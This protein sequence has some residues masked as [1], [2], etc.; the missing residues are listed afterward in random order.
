M[1]YQLEGTYY[2]TCT[3]DVLC[4]CGATN[5]VLPADK[6]RCKVVLGFKVDSGQ[7]DGVDVAGTAVAILVDAPAQMT[8][9]NWRVGMIV[10]ERASEEQRQKLVSVFSGEQGGPGAAFSPLVGEVLGVEYAPIECS[11]DGPRHSM[12]VGDTIDF[13]I[14]DF[15]AT[16]GSSPMMLEGIGHPAGTR[17]TI[18][19]ATRSSVRGFGIEVDGR[20]GH[21][22]N[23]AWAG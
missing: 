2:E 12:R 5:L 4:P 19:R 6:E 10:D 1:A 17:L 3:C 20:N 7:I 11:D 15:L 23:F 22:T 21:A 14:E 16:D 13:E 9:G 18:A 8:D